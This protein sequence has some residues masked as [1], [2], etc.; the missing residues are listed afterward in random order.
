M[1]KKQKDMAIV[2]A[3]LLVIG[4][5]MMSCS[6]KAGAH[7]WYDMACCNDEDCR[8]IPSSEVWFEDDKWFWKSSAT[9]Q[10][11][12][13]H[14]DSRT[15]YAKGQPHEDLGYRVRPSKDQRYHGC[16]RPMRDEKGNVTDWK[17]DCLYVPGMF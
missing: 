6:G 13:F 7:S 2:G 5:I 12:V 8:P 17:A 11:H 14:K 15:D 3:V 1:D 4:A 16:E 9:G 10:L